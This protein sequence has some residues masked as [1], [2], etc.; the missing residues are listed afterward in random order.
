MKKNVELQEL[1]VQEMQE[2]NGGGIL[3]ILVCGLIGVIAG[4]IVAALMD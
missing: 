2:V 3:T 4:K 1:T